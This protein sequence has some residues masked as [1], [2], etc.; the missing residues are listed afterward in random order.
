M[1]SEFCRECGKEF[2][3]DQLGMYL[4]VRDGGDEYP[5]TI[6]CSDCFDDYINDDDVEQVTSTA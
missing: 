3:D 5:E 1:G 2:P 6:L 4:V